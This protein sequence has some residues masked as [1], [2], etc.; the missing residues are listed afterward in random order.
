MTHKMMLLSCD[1]F[2]K[3]LDP[4]NLLF[5]FVLPIC[6]MLV[7][8]SFRSRF[9][10]SYVSS[11]DGGANEFPDVHFQQREYHLHHGYL[12]TYSAKSNEQRTDDQVGS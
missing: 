10:G 8:P 4:E 7:A 1:V 12:A 5:C 9:T 2:V 11:N 6:M 3:F